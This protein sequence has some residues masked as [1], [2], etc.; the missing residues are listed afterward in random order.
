M[1]KKNQEGSIMQAVAYQSPIPVSEAKKNF[2]QLYKLAEAGR[3]VLTTKKNSDLSN[4]SLV[5]S[6]I[7]T[8]MFDKFVIPIEETSDDVVGGLTIAVPHLPIYGE[9][10]TREEAIEDLID[11]VIEFREAYLENLE[12][13][14]R[15]ESLDNKIVMLKLLRCGND[16]EAIRAALKV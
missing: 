15:S 9:G 6:D 12:L 11:A 4:V 7:L 5:N 3:E 14:K 8:A 13:Y 16:R 2:S 1:K 10:N